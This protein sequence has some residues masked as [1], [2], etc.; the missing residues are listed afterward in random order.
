MQ[1]HAHD[2]GT[3]DCRVSMQCAARGLSC[4]GNLECTTRF[5]G[6]QELEVVSGF[7]DKL[8]QG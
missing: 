6:R 8:L 2:T 7:C 3:H 4:L 5:Q 1:K